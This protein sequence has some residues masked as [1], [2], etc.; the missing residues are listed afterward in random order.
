[1]I[2]RTIWPLTL[3]GV[4]FIA[5]CNGGNGKG[6]ASQNGAVGAP[7]AGAGT[8][9]ASVSGSATGAGNAP[10]RR[11]A[12]TVTTPICSSDV[13]A[14]AGQNPL[15]DACLTLYEACG[16]YV[17]IID[18]Y[19][20]QPLVTQQRHYYLGVAYRGL[21]MRNRSAAAQ[22]QL[23]QAAEA[24]LSEYLQEATTANNQPNAAQLNDLRTFQQV[25]HATNLLE[26]VKTIAG[27]QSGGATYYDIFQLQLRARKGDR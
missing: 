19:A 25:Y 9:R 10:V 18:Y 8:A 17:D 3:L 23:G 15:T 20:L 24:E 27:C 14:C 1:M 26:G 21:F 4:A 22:C 12:T 6:K 16:R 7:D 11:A 2:A 13:T 5:A